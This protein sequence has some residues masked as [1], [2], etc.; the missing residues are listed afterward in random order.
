MDIIFATSLSKTSERSLHSLLWGAVSQGHP[1]LSV[2]ESLR[3]LLDCLIVDV[4]RRFLSPGTQ[5]GR[6]KALRLSGL[7]PPWTG[8]AESVLDQTVF[9]QHGLGKVST[10]SHCQVLPALACTADPQ[11]TIQ[12]RFSQDHPSRTAGLGVFAFP[13]VTTFRMHQLVRQFGVKKTPQFHLR[14]S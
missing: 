7:G 1:D 6:L 5:Q 10:S 11:F 3:L 4:A 2:S 9:I 8:R 13:S 14:R 12:T